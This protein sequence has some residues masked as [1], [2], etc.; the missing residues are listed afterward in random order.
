MNNEE[1][2]KAVDEVV[3]Q[4]ENEERD[5]AIEAYINAVV[6]LTEHNT[7]FTVWS[8]HEKLP[9]PYASQIGKWA[10]PNKERFALLVGR[11]VRMMLAK[12]LMIEK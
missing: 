5:M 1:L 8:A 9:E 7:R 4:A 10:L 11:M 12:E 6:Q 3:Q 2:K